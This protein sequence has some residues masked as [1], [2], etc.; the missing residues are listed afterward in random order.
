MYTTKHL[1]GIMSELSELTAIDK[2]F[3]KDVQKVLRSIDIGIPIFF[4]V[5]LYEKLNLVY[6]KQAKKGNTQ[7]F[8]TD[9]GKKILNTII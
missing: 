8:L 3:I 4:N 2:S 5:T 6:S 7:F 1:R 9:K